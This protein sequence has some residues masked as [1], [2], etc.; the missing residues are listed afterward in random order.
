[1]VLPNCRS[2][3]ELQLDDNLYVY[4]SSGDEPLKYDESRDRRNSIPP[5]KLPTAKYM[6]AYLPRPP[7]ETSSHG[8]SSPKVGAPNNVAKGL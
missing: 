7:T 2:N 8:A 4:K 5:A 3:I 6:L 1:M